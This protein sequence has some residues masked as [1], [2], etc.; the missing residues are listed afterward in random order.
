MDE[1][2]QWRKYLSTLLG[3]LLAF[4]LVGT[5]HG[6][7][8]LFF[9]IAIL[10]IWAFYNL[11]RGRTQPERRRP[12][13]VKC[14]LWLVTLVIIVGNHVY[15]FQASRRDADFLASKVLIF[16][17]AHGRYPVDMQEAGITD[18]DFGRH[19]M[20]HYDAANGQPF[21]LY[22][23]TFIVFDTYDYD[24]QTRQWRYHSD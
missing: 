3:A 17:T 15:L 21:M 2:K 16:K 8:M 9:L 23:A 20:L 10:L 18:P 14:L 24:F 7:F 22:A 4:F 13:A 1:L 5:N 6:G 11:I 19:W 12:F